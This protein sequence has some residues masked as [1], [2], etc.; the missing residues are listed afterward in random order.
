MAERPVF[1]PCAFGPALVTERSFSFVWSPGFAAVQKKK[2]IA[3]LH[4]AAAAAGYAPRLEVSTKSDEPLGQRLSA[5]NLRVP[6]SE[7]G[8]LPLECAF[9]ASKVFERG[10]PYTELLAAHPR[11]AIRDSRIGMN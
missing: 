2:S 10:A 1:F 7:R 3:A 4:A 11:D 8:D 9:Q 5:F 6:H